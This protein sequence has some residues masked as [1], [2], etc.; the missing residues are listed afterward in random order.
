MRTLLDQSLPD[1]GGAI[2]PRPTA[3][4]SRLWAKERRIDKACFQWH[5][6]RHFL[7]WELGQRYLRQRTDFSR[8]A[9]GSLTL[10]GSSKLTLDLSGLTSPGLVRGIVTDAGQS[11][12]FG[13]VQVIN[14]P[15]SFGDTIIYRNDNIDVSIF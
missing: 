14:N 9:A 3:L 7:E 6:D 12:T 1:A 11:G 8:L 10:G 13:T 5:S 4:E 2:P 15:F